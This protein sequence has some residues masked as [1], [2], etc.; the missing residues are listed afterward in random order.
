MKAPEPKK[1][2]QTAFADDDILPD[3]MPA[4]EFPRSA[5]SSNLAKRSSSSKA[6]PASKVSPTTKVNTG[7]VPI[8]APAAAKRMNGAMANTYANFL[9]GIEFEDEDPSIDNEEREPEP[10]VEENL[11]AIIQD[12]LSVDRGEVKSYQMANIISQAPP[13][14]RRPLEKLGKDI[15]S[16]VSDAPKSLKDIY[17]VGSFTNSVTEIQLMM[18]WVLM[19]GHK[20]SD[21]DYNFPSM[22][23]YTP[24]AELWQVDDARFLLVRETPKD[25]MNG[26]AAAETIEDSFDANYEIAGDIIENR[27][28]PDSSQ[29]LY[30]VYGW[31]EPQGKVEGGGVK[32]G[33][34]EAALE[35]AKRFPGQTVQEAYDELLTEYLREDVIRNANGDMEETPGDVSAFPPPAPRAGENAFKEQRRSRLRSYR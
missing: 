23:G 9:N 32:A 34:L 2:V 16:M 22:P 7:D 26:A 3:D 30:Y 33:L 24:K 18:A 4:T 10:P 21:V 15:F 35:I 6:P 29:C 19:H 1:K 28:P 13:S 31:D 11:P 8:Q 14:M 20:I 12:A 17:C 25:F 5:P 27:T